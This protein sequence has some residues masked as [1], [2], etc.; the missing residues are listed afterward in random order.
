MDRAAKTE[1]VAA[2]NSVLKGTNV[3]VV[4]QNSG[5]TV[6]QMQTLRKQM[7]QAGAAVKVTKNRLAKIALDGTD[8]AVVIPL[9]KG[10]TVIAYS[11]DPIAAPKVATDFAKANEKFVI[12]GGAMGKTALDRNGI[13]ALAALPSLDELRAKIVGLIQAPA[14]KIAQVIVAPATKVAR[15]VAAYADKSEA[16]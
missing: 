9:L 12:L 4:A 5:L 14:T 8:A 15:V 11:G 7:K 3:V 13:Q 10:P 2:L 6:A 1:L 16:A